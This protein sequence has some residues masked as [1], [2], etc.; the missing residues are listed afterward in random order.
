MGDSVKSYDVI[1]FEIASSGEDGIKFF[2]V[3]PQNLAKFVEGQ[4]YAQY[5]NADIRYVN[6]YT[7]RKSETPLFVTT[8]E[9]EFE[10]DS[11]FPIKTFRNFE[12]DPLAAITGAISD[13][14]LGSNAW[15]QIIVRPVSNYWQVNSK[16]YITS[17]REGKN[18]YGESFLDKVAGFLS[19]V[20]RVIANPTDEVPRKGLLN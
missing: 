9:V 11:I 4:I 10:K 19:G 20:G 18:P 15:I 17:I 7:T 14:K 16:K 1:S 2:V 12:V 8:G 3:V 5:P 13:L 6:D